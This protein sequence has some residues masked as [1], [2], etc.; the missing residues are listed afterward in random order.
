MYFSLPRRYL[1]RFNIK[2][3][4]RNVV[5]SDEITSDR[6]KKVSYCK[7]KAGDKSSKLCMNLIHFV[8]LNIPLEELYQD[9][10]VV[11]YDKEIITC[12]TNYGDPRIYILDVS[13]K[14]GLVDV[15]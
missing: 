13:T 8:G 9:T 12:G 1:Y 4:L 2:N 14:I 10:Y 7:R 5:K 15:F 6:E 11:D 3:L